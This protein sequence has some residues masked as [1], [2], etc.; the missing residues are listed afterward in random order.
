[1]GSEGERILLRKENELSAGDRETES[2]RMKLTVAS[3]Q[4]PAGRGPSRYVNPVAN[5][6]LRREIEVMD[7]ESPAL[8]LAFPHAIIDDITVLVDCS[9][10]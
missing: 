6:D 9:A 4:S 5:D 1:M 8:G 3:P 10:R 7:W 2:S